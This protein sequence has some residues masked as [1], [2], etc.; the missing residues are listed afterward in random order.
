MRGVD[1][2]FRITEELLSLESMKNTTGQDLYECVVNAI[3]KVH[4]H[5]ID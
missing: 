4:Y 5:G 3:G 2:N 1:E